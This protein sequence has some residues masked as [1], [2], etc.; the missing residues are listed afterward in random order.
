MLVKL[1]TI[2]GKEGEVNEK[3]GGYEI[4]VNNPDFF[5]WKD[6]FNLLVDASYEIWI[7]RQANRLIILSKP[8]VD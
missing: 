4:I 3:Y 5:P 1:R 7:K 6:V 8:S 2:V